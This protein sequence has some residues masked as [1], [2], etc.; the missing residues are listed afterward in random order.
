MKIDT[1]FAGEVV[2]KAIQKGA[3][4]AEVFVRASRNLSLEIK[5]QAVDSLE[6]SLSFGY[7]LRIIRDGRL[8]FSYSNDRQ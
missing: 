2:S 8:G 5:D 4:L 7:S 1:G 3:D 6:S